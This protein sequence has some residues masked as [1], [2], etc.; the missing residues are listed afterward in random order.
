MLDKLVSHCQNPTCI[1][2][3]RETREARKA[4]LKVLFQ[5]L[6]VHWLASLLDLKE[7]KKNQ[8]LIKRFK[9]ELRKKRREER[10]RM[11]KQGA[12]VSAPTGYSLKIED[13]GDDFEDDVSLDEFY[14]E[15]CG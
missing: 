7:C 13:E 2:L 9:E 4:V 1:C 3:D 11:R 10:Q 6:D 8:P 15:L 5:N 12:P 14:E